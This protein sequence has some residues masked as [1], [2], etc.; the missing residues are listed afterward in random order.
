MMFIKKILAK[1]GKKVNKPPRYP[2]KTEVVLWSGGKLVKKA[3]LKL[4]IYFFKGLNYLKKFL[5]SILFLVNKPFG[6]LGNLFLVVL[7]LRLY[8]PYLFLKR[9]IKQAL[10]IPSDNKKFFLFFYFIGH[11]CTTYLIVILIATLVA[12]SNINAYNEVTPEDFG[13]KTI[14]FS[15]LKNEEELII[16]DRTSPAICG[17]ITSYLGTEDALKSITQSEPPKIEEIEKE[18][19]EL[20]TIITQEGSA[21]LKPPMTP[22][23]TGGRPQN[24]IECY[25]VQEGDTIG[26]IAERFG[27]SVTTL[28]WEN[29]LSA[30][31]VIK[32]G[33]KLTILPVSGLSHKIEKGDTLEGIAKKYE[34]EMEK[35]IE[36]NKLA[37]ANDI[38]PNE[39]LIIPGGKKPAPPKPR[40]LAFIKKL[41]SPSPVPV[42]DSKLNWPVNSRRITQY[43]SWR[44]HGLDIG[45]PHG[46]PVC[47][48]EEG[49]IE[50]TKWE[51]GY[52]NYI[53]INHGGG[54]KTVYAHLSKIFVKAGQTVKRGESIGTVGSTGRSTGPH[55]H[56]EVRIN[57]QKINPLKYL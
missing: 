20:G 17:K 15:L 54:E 51:S 36:F 13:Q 23:F 25:I 8:K 32:P 4:L 2:R 40:P 41:F 31:S 1:I 22:G 46:S 26:E 16:E 33:K 38:K 21:I 34:V 28:L 9:K 57:G 42:T 47:A 35:I 18:I 5:S 30:K 39:I 48:A 52:G 11:R 24:K 3:A 44:H 7:I 45:S 12:I 55:L 14:L 53:V 27:V 29:E 6:W 49:K 19:E 37:S 43:F 50:L 56:F 10:M